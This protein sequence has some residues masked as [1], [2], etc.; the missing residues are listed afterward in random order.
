M[1]DPREALATIALLATVSACGAPDRAPPPAPAPLAIELAG[2]AQIPG[3]S[4]CEL[5][6][7]ARDVTV[8]ARAIS[9]R[10]SADGAPLEPLE[11][12]A[13]QGGTRLRLRVPS[14]ARELVVST[15]GARAAIV[16]RP[17]QVPARVA[18]LLAMRRRGELDEVERALDAWEREPSLDDCDRARLVGVQARVAFSRGEPERVDALYA[19]SIP[20]LL[21]CGRVSEAVNDA[22]ARAYTQNMQ[23]RDFAAARATLDAIA[24]RSAPFA[25]GAAWIA[26][27]RASLAMR[28]GELGAAMQHLDDAEQRTERIALAGLRSDLLQMRGWIYG[29]L[30]RHDRAASSVSE[31]SASWDAEAPCDRARLLGNLGWQ[32]LLAAEA[33]QGAPSDARAPLALALEI[34]DAACPDGAWRSQ[35]HLTLARVA[36]LEG[37]LAEAERALQRAGEGASS[38]DGS[39]AIALLDVRGRLALDAGDARGA[40]VIYDE[41]VSRARA[42]G[43]SVPVGA[44]GRARALLALGREDDAIDALAESEDELDRQIASVSLGMGRASL[45]VGRSESARLLVEALIDRGR[46]D[47][48]FL[49]ARRARARVLGS[50]PRLA[51]TLTALPDD[52]RRARER[53]I[54]DYWAVRQ[55]IESLARQAFTVPADELPAIERA[56]AEQRA[57]L[58]AQLERLFPAIH[59][60]PRPLVVAPGEVVLG[61]F[62]L[63]DRTFVFVQDASGVRASTHP[64]DAPPASMLA[65]VARAAPRSLRVIAPTE[66]PLARVHELALGDRGPLGLAMPIEH[67]VDL[68]RT[69]SAPRDRGAGVFVFDPRGDLPGARR[70]AAWLREHLGD[71]SPHTWLLGRDATRAAVL[72]ALERA[73]FLH[74]AGHAVHVRDVWWESG[75]LL[76]ERSM[77]TVSDVLAARAVP[78]EIVLAACDTARSDP[79]RHV[80]TVGIAQAFVV[81]GADHVVATLDAVEDA[82]AL[83]FSRAYH[84]TS[85]RAPERVHHASRALA[86][87]GHPWSTFVLLAP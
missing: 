5:G 37:A 17:L 1:P 64:G 72:A 25:E 84:A 10:A 46:A 53:A 69:T 6:D 44:L 9:V 22:L 80:A 12:V 54:A 63:G 76:G 77:L 58:A 49:A 2:C 41:L 33:G 70:E 38:A 85:G 34:P 28:L 65:D 83:A 14:G 36:V 31:A 59:T 74:Y 86:A 60:R 19:A 11:S 42:A 47:D 29:L 51:S 73:R 7:D 40:L 43:E 3:E 20:A 27:Q 16:V 35:V 23:L 24:P 66:G 52:E 48:A 75:L 18:T 71:A 61:L 8:F 56:Q 57:R 79:A 62:P 32:R 30:G 78:E 50:L 39:L 68:P 13:A 21:A 87:A 4:V 55:R 82:A 15:E 45:S 67:V 81:A 26:Y